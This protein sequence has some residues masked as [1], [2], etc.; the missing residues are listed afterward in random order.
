[1]KAFGIGAAS[2]MLYKF[3][4]KMAPSAM[5][6]FK[7]GDIISKGPGPLKSWTESREFP[8]PN[9]ESFRDWFKNRDNRRAIIMNGTI[10]NEGDIFSQD[11]QE[12]GGVPHYGRH[13]PPRMETCP[14]DGSLETC[15]TRR[16]R[17]GITR[18]SVTR[19]HTQVHLTGF[20]QYC[21]CFE[22]GHRR[23]WTWACH[24]P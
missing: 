14:T 12:L 11:S 9:K 5:S 19:I 4:S 8:A 22:T 13:I 17:R 24:H 15:N 7:T 1:M 6:P 18:S 23:T 2:P 3:G 21:T 10:Q 20:K 16:A